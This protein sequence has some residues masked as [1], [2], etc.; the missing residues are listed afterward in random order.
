MAVVI[1][2]KL[3]LDDFERM[4]ECGAFDDQDRDV[5]LVDGEIVILPPP[6]IV[7]D[8]VVMAIVRLLLPFAD[9]I[10][11]YVSSSGLGIRAGRNYRQADV[12]LILKERLHI[13]HGHPWWTLGAPDL[14]IEVLSPRRYGERYART[15]VPE[16]LAAGASLV[17]LVNP[18]NRTVRVFEAGTDEVALHSGDA[19]ITLD[20]LAPG[21]RAS[22]SAFFPE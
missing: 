18:R 12:S 8:M 15:K 5:E 7:H 20:Q 1:E 22:I 19:K 11:A 9:A 13:L 4:I 16:Y 10:G 17:W 3:T 6:G 21:F 2:R 14:A